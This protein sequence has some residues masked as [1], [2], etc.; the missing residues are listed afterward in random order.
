MRL[1]VCP[2]CIPIYKWNPNFQLRRSA[3]GGVNLCIISGLCGLDI[4]QREDERQE[5]I[6]VL[7]DDLFPRRTP[8][9]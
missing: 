1:W 7:R 9:R 6:R 5:L 8:G 2:S 3:A 4:G